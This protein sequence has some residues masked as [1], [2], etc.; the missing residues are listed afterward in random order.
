MALAN[1]FQQGPGGAGPAGAPQ[2]VPPPPPPV[3]WHV[4]Q[5]GQTTGPFTVAQLA[6]SA[7]AGVFRRDMLVWSAGMA[8]WITASEVAALAGVFQK[9]LAKE[10]LL[11]VLRARVG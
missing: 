7:A 3:L 11:G 2:V 9:P 5:N 4:V 6:Q 8:G 1:Q 10:H